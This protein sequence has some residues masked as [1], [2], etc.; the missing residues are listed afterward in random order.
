M[1]ILKKFNNRIKYELGELYVIYNNVSIKWNKENKVIIEI[2]NDNNNIKFILDES[3]P[4]SAPN[5]LINNV[6]YN[7]FVK[8]P[9]FRMKELL[10]KNFNK[11]C[12][13]CSSLLHC[14]NWTPTRKFTVVVDEIITI[15]TFKK[16]ICNILLIDKIKEK[17][18][19]RD[20]EI[21]KFLF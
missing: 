6:N 11:K 1:N 12:L 16:N 14:N 15:Q 9:S 20:I 10:Y 7:D 13:C 8:L 5:A 4:F 19:N 21:Q 3:Y 17:Y 2:S 18:L